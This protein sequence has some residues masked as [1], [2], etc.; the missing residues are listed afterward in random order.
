MCLHEVGKPSLHYWGSLSVIDVFIL[1]LPH[2]FYFISTTIILYEQ[3]A[4]ELTD[5][6]PVNLSHD[7][8]IYLMMLASY[9]TELHITNPKEIPSLLNNAKFRN[10]LFSFSDNYFRT[11]INSPTEV[12]Y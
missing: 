2:A 4:T 1:V 3:D 6:F 5:A 8:L 11:I 9:V 7:S 12:L 10:L